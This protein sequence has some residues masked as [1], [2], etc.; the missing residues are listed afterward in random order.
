MK[1]KKNLFANILIAVG[2][3]LVLSVVI[4]EAAQYPWRIIF[5]R[6]GVVDKNFTESTSLPA[7]KPLPKE[8]QDPTAPPAKEELNLSAEIFAARPKMNL[9]LL[10]DIKIPKINISENIVEGSGNEMYYGVGHV[11]NSAMPGQAGNCV[12]AAH[13]IYVY[14]RPFRHLD[15]MAV[16]DI[17]YLS[18]DNLSYTYQIYDIFEIEEDESW[19]LYSSDE[20]EYMLTLITC[21]P[22]I[23]P[24]RRLVCRARLIQTEPLE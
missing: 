13:R 22:V 7:P 17:V 16:D 3:L 20:E 11:I 24:T 6:A 12:L 5:S 15:K 18:D 4:F 23:N 1:L 10:G 21:T 9:T 8:A 14:M 2:I 19:V